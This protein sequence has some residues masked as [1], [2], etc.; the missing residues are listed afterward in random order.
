MSD[1]P[2]R[3]RTYQPQKARRQT[4]NQPVKIKRRPAGEFAC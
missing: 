2:G 4:G 1:W 3:S